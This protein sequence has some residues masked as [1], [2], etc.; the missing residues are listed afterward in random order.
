MV[1]LLT[2]VIHNIN[3]MSVCCANCHSPDELAE[4]AFN[5]IQGLDNIK[6]EK[7]LKKKAL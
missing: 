7:L 3:G 4:V 2:K 5:F 1:L 6:Q